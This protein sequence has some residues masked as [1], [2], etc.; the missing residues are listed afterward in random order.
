MMLSNS[1]IIS[2]SHTQPPLPTGHILLVKI[3]NTE[4]QSRCYFISYKINIYSVAKPTRSIKKM[5]DLYK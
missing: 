5:E 1:V 2:Y 3:P 4:V